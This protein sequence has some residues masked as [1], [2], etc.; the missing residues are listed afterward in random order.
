[1]SCLGIDKFSFNLRQKNMN[2]NKKTT[3]IGELAD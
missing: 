3:I 1:M 2:I